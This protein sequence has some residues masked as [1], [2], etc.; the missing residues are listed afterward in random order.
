[1]DIEALKKLLRKQYG[2]TT[3]K[4]LDDA[5]NRIGKIDIGLFLTD[6]TAL[7]EQNIA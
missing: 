6:E 5:L 4:Q 2:I 1:M 3:I 7:S